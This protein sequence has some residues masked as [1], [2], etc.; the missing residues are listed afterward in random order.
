VN[1]LVNP[2]TTLKVLKYGDK[3]VVLEAAY[4]ARNLRVMEELKTAA[5]ASGSDMPQPTSE[6]QEVLEK[7]VRVIEYERDGDEFRPDDDL[8]QF[9]REAW[10][11][12]GE[13]KVLRTIKAST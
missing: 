9:V 1:G 10:E 13:P 3:Q 7:R 2:I 4:A 6:Y 8:I 11:V 5:K 12:L